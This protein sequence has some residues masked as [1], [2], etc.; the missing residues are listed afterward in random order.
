[1]QIVQDVNILKQISE[2]VNSVSEAIDIIEKLKIAL[3][4]T[5]HGV[6]LAAIQIGI[7]KKI[8]V[9]NKEYF[10][11]KK[12]FYLINTKLIE[13]NNKFLFYSE[14]CLSF[15][16]IFLNTYRYEQI[17]FENCRIE[18][19]KLELEKHWAYYP[20]EKED[21]RFITN[22]KLVAIAIQHELDHFNGEIL[23]EYGIRNEPIVKLEQKVGRNDLCPCGSGKKYKKCCMIK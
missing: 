3:S 21:E 23:T 4:Q 5:D 20:I 1:M 22:H 7:P 2:P 15:P 17:L 14:G 18:G 11:D 12:Y 10:N 19:D 9:L 16:N 13:G 6:G 8:A